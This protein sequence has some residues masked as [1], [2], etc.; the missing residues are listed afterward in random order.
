MGETS[1]AAMI[2]AVESTMAA[3]TSLAA[4][5]MAA[6]TSPVAVIMA[7]ETTMPVGNSLAA[8]KT[9][10]V[11]NTQA[12]ATSVALGITCSKADRWSAL[13]S[14]WNIKIYCIPENPRFDHQRYL[15]P[16]K[17]VAVE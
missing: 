8:E 16:L 1:P 11:G 15:I 10:A 2:M 17:G 13:Y 5:I 3:A 7:V 9:L 4:V 12:P 6:E 14:N